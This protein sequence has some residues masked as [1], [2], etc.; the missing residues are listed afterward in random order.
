MFWD[1]HV[2]RGYRIQQSIAR[3]YWH[4]QHICEYT[5]MRVSA[6]QR[7]ARNELSPSPLSWRPFKTPKSW[8]VVYARSR[9][10][11]C[12]KKPAGEWT[13]KFNKRLAPVEILT[14]KKNRGKKRAISLLHADT[15]RMFSCTPNTHLQFMALVF[16]EVRSEV[17]PWEIVYCC[18]YMYWQTIYAA[19]KRLLN[20]DSYANIQFTSLRRKS[21]E[22]IS[23]AW[24]IYYK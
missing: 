24:L 9:R 8:R 11:S 1:T 13:G 18:M 2:W 14:A 6:A 10:R 3:R 4:V 15:S 7:A 23:S 21:P 5:C 16:S 17:L 19:G 12:K 20:K 22:V